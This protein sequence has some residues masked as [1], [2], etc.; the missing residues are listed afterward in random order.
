MHLRA[1]ESEAI[2]ECVISH[3]SSGHWSLLWRVEFVLLAINRLEVGVSRRAG[4][5]RLGAV[6]SYR[7][8]RVCVDA[9]TS[10]ESCGAFEIECNCGDAA[11]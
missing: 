6:Q 2:R 8:M 7:L 9:K 5:V 3:A 10:L 4:G 1:R 11:W